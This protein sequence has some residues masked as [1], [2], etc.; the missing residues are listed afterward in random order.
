[1]YNIK[2]LCGDIMCLLEIK[3]LTFNFGKK[4]IF[5]NLNLNINH[6]SFV[7]ISGKNTCGKTT[8]IKLLSGNIIT[9][10]NVKIDGIFINSINK[11]LIENKIC[12]FS[13]ENKYYSETVLD[14]LLFEMKKY[15]I[16]S[17]NKIKKYLNELNL[18]KY[19]DKSPQ[20]LN[21]VERQKLCLVKA[22]IK[23]SKLLLIDNIF[24]YFDQF[25]KIEFI[26][27]LKKYQ[28]KYNFSILMTITDLTDS[29]FTDR[30]II[31][32]NGKVLLDGSPEEIYKEEK[33][34]KRIG[35]NLPFNYE[36]HN[37]LKLYNL[38]EGQSIDIDDM[39]QEICK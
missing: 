18:I 34:L 33:I 9:D 29:I 1:M 38:I 12:I 16:I 10:N 5:D 22:I 24:S 25:S 37:K 21:Y 4:K 19:I 36:L 6:Q 7:S 11:D 32:N 17:L 31:I 39:V 23:E 15:D 13:P 26:S 20:V 8:L 27:L 28:Q 3:N 2:L 30:L 14:E 35:L